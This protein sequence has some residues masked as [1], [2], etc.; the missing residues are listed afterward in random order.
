MVSLA[1]KSNGVQSNLI[2]A[3]SFKMGS[4]AGEAFGLSLRSFVLSEHAQCTSQIWGGR[5]SPNS[6]SNSLNNS[7]APKLNFYK[8][9]YD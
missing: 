4:V 5:P 2:I 1:F 7:L 6:L 8:G 9:F 3:C